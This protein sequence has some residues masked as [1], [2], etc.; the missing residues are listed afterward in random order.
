MLTE[1][2]ERAY[3]GLAHVERAL[4]ANAIHTLLVTDM[5]FRSKKV[6]ERKRYVR[7]VEEVRG[8]GGEVKVFSSLHVS[9]QQLAQLSGVA[10]ILRFP[11]PEADM[12]EARGEEQAGAAAGGSSKKC[13]NGAEF[14]ST[15]SEHESSG[16]EE[17]EDEW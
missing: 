1:N 17:V 11:M 15:E 10:A 3:Y 2:P 13:A 9:G 14:S 5:L 4:D 7:L 8:N 16:G 6:E 12:D